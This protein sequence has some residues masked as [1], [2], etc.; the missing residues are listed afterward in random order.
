MLYH[1]FP[2]ETVVE[3]GELIRRKPKSPNGILPTL[4]NFFKS[5][6]PGLWIAWQEAD[7][8]NPVP[9]ENFYIDRDEYPNLEAS[10]VSL[11]KEDINIFYK[12]FSKEAFWPA[13]FAFVEKVQFNYEH[14]EHYL[15]VNRI[16]AEKAAKEAAPNA[17]IWIHDYNLWMVPGYL[18]SCAPTLRSASSTTPLSRRPI[19]ST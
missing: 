5:G 12:V 2:F 13:I 19:R 6:R 7:G 14:W 11:Q 9:E 4:T 10:P 17:M 1:R 15:K 18:P 3:D 8:E 16:F